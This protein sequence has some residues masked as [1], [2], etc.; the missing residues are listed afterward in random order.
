ML[1]ESDG[2]ADVERSALNLKYYLQRAYNYQ[3]SQTLTETSPANLSQLLRIALPKS[4]SSTIGRFLVSQCEQTYGGQ[5]YMSTCNILVLR[6][7]RVEN[8]TNKD[9][10]RAAIRVHIIVLSS[11]S[12]VGMAWG[13]EDIVLADITVQVCTIWAHLYGLD[14][15][16]KTM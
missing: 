7:Q 9:R 14:D 13:V 2:S 16:R 10:S 11:L 8:F 15:C 1:P 6:A 3:V 4:I 12:F 5:L